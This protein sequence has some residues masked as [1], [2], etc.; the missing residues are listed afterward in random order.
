MRI[1]IQFFGGRGSGGGKRSGGGRGKK[2]NT[3]SGVEESIRNNSYESAVV[4]DKDGKIIMNKTGSEHEV[5]FSKAD[6]ASMKDGVLTHNHPGTTSAMSTFSKADVDLA[7]KSGLQQMRAV[8]KD[9]TYTL[10]KVA[11]KRSRNN[12]ASDYGD[13]IRREGQRLSLSVTSDKVLSQ[14]LTAFGSNWLKNN[15]ND[16]GYSYA[17]IKK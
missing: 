2:E 17:E 11:N 4:F 1:S 12:F 6:M 8:T 15:S 9:T 5:K 3:L 7:T 13:A 10:T 14:K 16:Y